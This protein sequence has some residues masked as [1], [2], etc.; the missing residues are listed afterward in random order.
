M[1]AASPIK[2]SRRLITRL[3]PRLGARSVG[4]IGVV[5]L[6]GSPTPRSVDDA[7]QTRDDYREDDAIADHPQNG[8]SD[9]ELPIPSW[10]PAWRIRI[11]GVLG[12]HPFSEFAKSPVRLSR[13]AVTEIVVL[14]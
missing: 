5:P 3:P 6:H 14:V 1:Q 10:N 2:A 12:F 7:E 9:E 13:L 8:V 11:N 4:G